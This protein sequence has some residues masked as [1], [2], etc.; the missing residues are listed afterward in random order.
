[1]E[2]PPYV[3]VGKAEWRGSRLL[4]RGGD[5]RRRR[6]ERLPRRP[7]LRR[8]S[9]FSALIGRI[10]DGAEKKAAGGSGRFGIRFRIAP[11]PSRISLCPLPPPL[12]G[13][14]SV[15]SHWFERRVPL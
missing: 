13:V 4:S 5:R 7:E 12:F 2:E 9:Q 8:F 14:K 11:V 3:K 15:S 6:Y 1:M 10:V